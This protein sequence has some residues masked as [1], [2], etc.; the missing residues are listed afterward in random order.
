MRNGWE[1]SASAW[2]AD[3]GER[4]D[5]S[6]EFVLDAPMMESVRA[7]RC[8]TALDV[9]CGEGRF[10]RMM[11]TSGI[12]T[13]GIDPTE[14]LI[15][16]AREHDTD[17]DYRVGR[18]E[19]IDFAD[20]TFDLVVSYLSLI[21]IADVASAIREM[22]RVLRPG[23][24][25]LIA[26]LTSFNTAA[27]GGG[28]TREASGDLRF[29]IDHYLTQRAVWVARRGIRVQNWHRPLS[30]YMSLLIAEGLNLRYFGE[31]APIGGESA[32]A[33][34]YERVPWSMI[35]EWEKPIE[36]IAKAAL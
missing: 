3:M 4:G 28:W 8:S 7:K 33:E 5:F 17:G 21:D 23:G 32:K 12:Q 19:A 15:S 29:S 2:I 24:R 11:Q 25:L 31:P 22:V 16:R 9:G 6:R 26:N 20:Q 27:V 30:F 13:V 14:A 35:M 1:E 34:R 10:C 18:A 36:T